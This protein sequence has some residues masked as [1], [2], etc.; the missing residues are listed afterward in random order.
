MV[1]ASEQVLRIHVSVLLIVLVFM[2]GVFAPSHAG[3]LTSSGVV[4]G[5]YSDLEGLS[6]STLSGLADGDTIRLTD[7]GVRGEFVVKTGTVTANNGTMFV[8]DNDTTR[9][10]QRLYSGAVNI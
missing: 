9:Y 1:Q 4:L 3:A 6:S 5:G 2:W 10:A 8:F 7:D